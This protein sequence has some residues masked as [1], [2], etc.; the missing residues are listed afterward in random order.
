MTVRGSWGGTLR[1]RNVFRLLRIRDKQAEAAVP[2]HGNRRELHRESIFAGSHFPRGADASPAAVD[3]RHRLVLRQTLLALCRLT[4]STHV[5]SLSPACSAGF[6]ASSGLFR[7]RPKHRSRHSTLFGQGGVLMRLRREQF[8]LTSSPT[9]RA[10]PCRN[11][12]SRWAAS[13]PQCSPLS[14]SVPRPL[15]TTWHNCG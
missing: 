14:P 7:V 6:D 12:R 13:P 3:L 5:P 11:S 8:I 9:G 15:K 10:L 1:L 2:L 4:L